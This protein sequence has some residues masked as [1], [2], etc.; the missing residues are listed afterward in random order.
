MSFSESI[1]TND[2]L[3]PIDNVKSLHSTTENNIV[4]LSPPAN[5]YSNFRRKSNRILSL[6]KSN[7]V[8]QNVI[9]SSI[10]ESIVSANDS[11]LSTANFLENSKKPNELSTSDVS[12]TS[13]ITSS[14]PSTSNQTKNISTANSG[15]S[16]RKIQVWTEDDIRWFFEALCEVRFFKSFFLSLKILFLSTAKIFLT[17]KLTLHPVV[18]KKESHQI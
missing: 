6:K 8:S 3:S 10:E 1:V 13:S 14:V 17:F 2:V 7:Q 18:R 16:L 12:S 15:K 9:S 4:Q 5:K 11:S